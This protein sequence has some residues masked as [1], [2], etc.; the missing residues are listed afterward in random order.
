MKILITGACGFIGVNFVRLLLDEHPQ[1]EIVALDKLTYAGNLANLDGLLEHE[2]LSFL[3]ADICDA[4][5]A[6]NAME[7]CDAVVH[8]AAE[9]HVD[10]SITGPGVFVQTNVLGTAT[11]LSA[12]LEAKITRFVQVSTDEVYGSLTLDDPPFTESNPITPSSPYSASKAGA[13]H[14]VQAYHH[15]FGMD[16]VITRCSNNYGPYQFPEKFIPLFTTHAMQGKSLPLY[17]DGSNI[18]DWIHVEDHCRAIDLVMRKGKSGQVYNIGGECE[19]SNRQIA[20]AIVRAVGADPGLIKL[21][22]DRPGHDWR[23]AMDSTLIREQ[24][25]WTPKVPSIESV[26]PKIVAWYKDNEAWWKA[27]QSQEYLHFYDEWYGQRL[28][29]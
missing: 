28:P 21:V 19:R 25:G 27:I 3:R 5:A 29:E 22:K 14:L 15:T 16:T 23:Y 9:S 4:Q 6:A 18:R 26:L 17:G 20:E 2:K 11:L 12:A 24:L 13:D 1:D 10:R 7:G 8:F